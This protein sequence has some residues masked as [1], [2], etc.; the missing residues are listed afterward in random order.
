MIILGGARV[1]LVHKPEECFNR[2]NDDLQ[3]EGVPE[4]M[5]SWPG[6][7]VL[8]WDDAK[9]VELARDASDGGCWTRSKF[10]LTHKRTTHPALKT[11]A[12]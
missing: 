7:D 12:A 2:D 10:K 1:V 4:F 8:G 11:D 6:S 9:P 3:F 5:R